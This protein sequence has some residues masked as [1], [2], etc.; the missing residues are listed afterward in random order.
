MGR[1]RESIESDHGRGA[2]RSLRR[3]PLRISK[4]RYAAGRQCHRRLWWASYGPW[5]PELQFDDAT[6]ALFRQGTRVGCVA[7]DHVP[8]GVL[9]DFDWR[10]SQ[11]GIAE[12]RRVIVEGAGVIY[13]AAFE[14]IRSGESGKVVLN[15]A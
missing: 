15:W 5:A 14:A 4:G 12:T 10:R 6:Q 13:E 9:I 2:S 7:R 11:E 3:T 1:L 8:G